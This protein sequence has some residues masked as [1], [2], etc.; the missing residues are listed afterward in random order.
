MP[1]IKPL[2]PRSRDEFDIAIICALSF[3]ADAVLALFD[4]HWDEDESGLSFGKARGDPNAYSAGVLGQHNVVLAHLPNMGKVA[5]GT[6]AAFCR[7]SYPNISLALV[8]GICGGAPFYG[9]KKEEILLGDVIISTGVVQYDIGRRFPNNF[10]IK[11]TLDDSLG[12]PSLEVRSLLSKLKTKRQQG[13]LQTATQ[14]YL[15]EVLQ[16]TAKSADYPTRSQDIVFPAN[17]RHKH[18]EPSACAICAACTTKSDPVC[19]N[20]L[21][22]TCEELKC[23]LKQRLIRS[24]LEEV[25]KDHSEGMNKETLFPFIHFGRFASGDT[26]MKSG[27]DRDHL[28]FSKDAI[29]F[30]ME[31]AGV[32]DVFPCVIIKSVSDY[33]DSHKNDNWQGLAAASAAGCTKAFLKYWYSARQESQSELEEKNP[34]EQLI[35]SLYFPE[36]NGRKNSLNPIAPLTFEW[37]FDVGHGDDHSQSYASDHDGLEKTLSQEGEMIP[38]KVKEKDSEEA[39]FDNPS[40]AQDEYSHRESEQA[41]NTTQSPRHSSFDSDDDDKFAGLS[42]SDA[43]WDSFLDWLVSDTPIYWISGNPG[44][45]K[46]TL[47]KYLSEHPSTSEHLAK[48]RI[49]T[50]LLSHFF[51]KPGTQMQQSFKGLLCSLLYDL[52]SKD[53]EPFHKAR[54]VYLRTRRLSTSDWSQN[55]LKSILLEYCQQSS[56]PI[57]VFVDALDEALPGKD[58][59]DIVQFL[60]SLASSSANVKVCV[61]SRPE[62]LF[63]LHFESCPNLKMHELTKLDIANYSEL[64]MTESTLLGPQDQKISDPARQIADLSDGIFLW[65]VLAT[66]SSIRGINNGDSREQTSRRLES[67]PQDLMDL[68]RDI[69]S[70]SAADRPIYQKYVTLIL[71]LILV[72]SWDGSQY[73]PLTTLVLTMAMNPDILDRYVVRGV[74]V[75]KSELESKVKGVKHTV[76]V[77]FVGLLEVK[78]NHENGVEEVVFPHR[79]VKDFLLD[80]IE[81]QNIW[82]PC[83]I[84]REEL[85]ARHFKSLLADGRLYSEDPDCNLTTGVVIR[86]LLRDIFEWEEQRSIPHEIIVSYLEL[87]RVSFFRGHLRHPRWGFPDLKPRCIEGEFLSHMVDYGGNQHVLYLLEKYG[88]STEE[89]IKGNGNAAD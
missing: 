66:Q 36:I 81:G 43:K 64:A 60:K 11:D 1:Q 31:S 16:E 34:V 39:P 54:D 8:V 10:E 69:L 84:P 19:E 17:Y 74:V 23:D 35:S 6:I 12:R 52:L 37:I 68:Y 22:S 67:M 14:G 57:C 28:T 29:G 61:S 87:A 75:Q 44:S 26:V 51:W 32:W 48:W 71:N 18:Q 62:R 38:E 9:N 46:S 20:A 45:G 58:V 83:D 76:E 88:E 47:M 13:K 24:R 85:W 42:L 56:K 41:N 3:E 80:T 63:R 73:Y 7:M 25:E 70:R 79:S 55:E 30:E 2:R 49:N 82:Q 40:D 53:P 59:L 33:A 4:H 89:S 86:D 5:A 78:F 21:K 65:A 50:V 77:A 15:L 27:E 72:N